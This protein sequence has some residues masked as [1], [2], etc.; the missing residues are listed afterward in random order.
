MSPNIIKILKRN[1]EVSPF[2]PAKITDAIWKAAQSVGGHDRAEAERL[3]NLVIARVNEK[4]HARSIP[5]VEEIQDV[6]ER[7][8]IEEGQVA[9]SKA[10]IL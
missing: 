1:G 6:V 4:F 7:I 5:A 3:T 10:Y 8:L 2:D 9:T